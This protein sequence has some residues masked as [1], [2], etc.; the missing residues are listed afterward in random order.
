MKKSVKKNIRSLNKLAKQDNLEL[1]QDKDYLW[2]TGLNTLANA[3]LGILDSTAVYV[4]KFSHLS[5]EQWLEEL[6]QIKK[7]M[8]E[9]ASPYY[10]GNTQLKVG[11]V[12]N[13]KKNKI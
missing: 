7:R 3:Q 8:K 10:D 11:E 9:D 4:A 1:V 2:W 6:D 13:T 12:Y 5:W